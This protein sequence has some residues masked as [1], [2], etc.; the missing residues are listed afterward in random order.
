[1]PRKLTAKERRIRDREKRLKRMPEEFHKYQKT[2]LGRAVLFGD[3]DVV[4]ESYNDLAPEY[5]RIADYRKIT[6]IQK[7][8]IPGRRD[9]YRK[10]KTVL[11]F[12]DN[13]IDTL[14]TFLKTEHKYPYTLSRDGKT[15]STVSIIGINIGI[16][17][18]DMDTGN[19]AV[20]PFRTLLE[21][22]LCISQPSTDETNVSQ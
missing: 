21:E 6:E 13:F 11:P 22:G 15:T 12:S 18:R 10:E 2:A 4:L 16:R 19:Y 14:V 5:Q 17:V 7:F 8:K 9:K 20:I 3:M 1:M